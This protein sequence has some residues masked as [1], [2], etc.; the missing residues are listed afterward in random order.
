[1]SNHVVGELKINSGWI[2]YDSSRLIV[3]VINYDYYDLSV[4]EQ[5]CEMFAHLC[6]MNRDCC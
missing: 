5:L 1:M 4:Q 3:V 6:L 2:H